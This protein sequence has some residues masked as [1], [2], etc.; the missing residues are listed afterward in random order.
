[1]IFQKQREI[2]RRKLSDTINEETKEV[3]EDISDQIN[4]LL[5]ELEKNKSEGP[6]VMVSS[7]LL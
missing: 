2:K 3:Q 7:G 4:S 6:L 1:L 5:G